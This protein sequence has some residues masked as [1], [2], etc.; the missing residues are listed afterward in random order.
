MIERTY[1]IGVK[2]ENALS[3]AGVQEAE[4][5]FAQ[6][7]SQDYHNVVKVKQNMKN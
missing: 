5:T 1:K 4:W 6:T 2:Q 3:V 7:V